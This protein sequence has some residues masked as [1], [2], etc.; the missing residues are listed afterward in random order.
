M[1]DQGTM[2]PVV[3]T[4][5]TTVSE[6]ILPWDEMALK[7]W[8]YARWLHYS[9][10]A[11]YGISHADNEKYACREI[12]TKDQRDEIARYLVE[13]QFDLE[14]VIGYPLNPRWFTDEQHRYGSIL[15]A[16]W[17]E[18]ISAGVE[19]ITVLEASASV[20]L[21]LDPST[22]T[23]A[24]ALTSTD[25]IRVFYTQ[26]DQEI[27]PYKMEIT[28]GNL[29]IYIP[30][31]RLLKWDLL[32]NP[33]EGYDYADSSIYQQNVKVQ[34]HETDP[35]INAD[36]VWAHS[37]DSICSSSG[38]SEY[39]NTACI[40][41]RNNSLGLVDVVP[42]EYSGGSWGT[43]ITTCCRGNPQYA[44]LNYRAGKQTLPHLM[45]NA[46]I[47]LAHARMQD[48]P[49]GC[50]EALRIWKR[51][52]AVPRLLTAERIECPFGYSDGAWRAWKYANSQAI[53]QTG[54]MGTKRS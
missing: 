35:S 44:R 21:V 22:V 51:D 16:R 38:C 39:T 45:E 28:G 7:L 26:E 52:S 42:A 9:E 43:N 40:Y 12:W 46:I 49:C 53:M 32:N 48:P 11:F 4:T 20:N 47:S 15:K 31:S 17:G 34:L 50:S 29:V 23:I 6:I 37:C 10:Y 1:T 36:L 24:T 41:I 2:T 27:F 14:D 30:K 8:K 18:I 13:A 5:P 19:E 25:G 33:S 3:G 54:F